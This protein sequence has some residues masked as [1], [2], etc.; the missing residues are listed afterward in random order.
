MI[1]V[2]LG[3]GGSGDI[4]LRVMCCSSVGIRANLGL[5][6][7]VSANGWYSAARNCLIV[8]VRVADSVRLGKDNCRDIARRILCCG[9]VGGPVIP[10]LSGAVVATGLPG[11]QAG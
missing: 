1:R 8:S 2:R 5:G 10:G 9:E 3:M 11:A 6:C 7:V 4:A